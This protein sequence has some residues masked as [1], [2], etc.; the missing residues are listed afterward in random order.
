MIRHQNVFGSLR[1]LFAVLAVQPLSVPMIEPAFNAALV[2]TIR[3]TPLL[4]PGFGSAPVTAIGVA[5]VAL[6]A[7]EK[8]R[9]A[10]TGS[11]KP[12]S[13]RALVGIGHPPRRS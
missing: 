12:L 9:A 1:A 3:F 8:H 5:A 7:N 2:T 4:A 13:Q 11:A 10:T 6:L